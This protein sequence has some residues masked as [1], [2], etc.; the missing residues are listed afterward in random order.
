MNRRQPKRIYIGY[1]PENRREEEVK[2]MFN[3]VGSV[4]K[5]VLYEDE[6]YVEY[7]THE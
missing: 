4:V 5:F 2:S 1:I 3:T 7:E 6:G